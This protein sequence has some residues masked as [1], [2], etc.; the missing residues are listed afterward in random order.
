MIALDRLP[1]KNDP[2]LPVL[3]LQCT[4]VFC[5]ITFWGFNRSPAQVGLI[6]AVCV[7]L[8]CTLH[9][10]LRK[11]TLLVPISGLITGLGLSVLTN[12][13]HGLWLALV[14]PFFATASK[15]VFTVN[16]RHIYNPGLFGVIAALVLSDGMITPSPA[17]QWGGAGITAFFIAT[18]ALML[19]A[20][21]IR[22]SVLIASFLVFYA[23]Q[24]GLRAWL[25]RHHIPPQTLFM[26]AFSSPAFYLFTFFMITDP[27]TSAQTPK[28][29]VFMA[30]FIVFVDL[31]LHKF[32]SFSTL[33]Y[34]AFA[35]MTLRGLWLLW[36]NRARYARPAAILRQEAKALLLT[37][38]IG[39]G[40][41][42]AYRAT[43]AFAGGETHFRFVRIPAAQSGIGGTQGDIWERT[44]PRMHHIAKWLLSVGDAAAVADA[45]NDGLPDIFLTQ[46]L[47][48]EQDR[49]QLFLNKGNFRFERFDIPQLAPHRTHPEQHGLIAAATWFDM[50][51]DGDRDL[52]LGTGFGK[53]RL[54]RNELKETG[55]LNFTEIGRQSGLDNYQISV[56]TNVLDLDNDGKLD[57]FVGNVMQTTLGGYNRPVPYNIFK[58]PA[59]EYEGDRRMFNVMHQ[60]WHNAD[61]AD[62]NLL[63]RNLG[64]GRFARIPQEQT[65]FSG[66]RWTMAAATGDLNGDGYADLYI[67][68][69]FGPDELYLNR[70]GKGFLA[71]KGS[72]SGSVGRDT[73]KG[74]NATFGDLDD[75]GRPDIHVSNVHEKLQA[76]GSL[77]WMNYSQ[78]GQTDAAA[79]RDEAARRNALNERRFGWGAA[80]GDLDRDGRL[81]FVQANGMADDAYDKK[82]AVCPDYWYWNAQIALTNPDVHGYADRWADVRG[83]CVF[84]SEANRIYMNKGGYFTDAAEQAGWTEKGTSRGMILAD[85]DNDGDLDSLVTHMT[86]APSLYR[87]DSAPAGWIGLQLAGNGTSCNRDAQGTRA[88][89]S[90]EDSPTASAQH[91]EV[92]ANNGLAAQNDPRILFGLGSRRAGS[93]RIGIQWCGRGPVQS[94]TLQTGRYHRI[95]QQ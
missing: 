51:N 67:A 29:Q 9:Y 55:R 76:E 81:D 95:T 10:L 85:F 23:M 84:G 59:P 2:R 6:L 15:Y 41:W 50:D 57:I 77:L 83:R 1:A 66:K 4:F 48:S 64:G 74:M 79:F 91:R 47:K 56:A 89:L 11:K 43:H 35:Y 13:S 46:P 14:P 32:Q 90:A 75:N 33:F 87:N 73:Y 18:A 39:L 21:N 58:L 26:G 65:G 19:F 78:P 44:D 92:Y 16:G 42:G 22:R 31:L 61:N 88:V 37:G 86:A 5:G 63:F 70:Q 60:S 40:G 20:L 62:E 28:G 52:L 7:V 24:L 38:L 3:L 34:A 54:L 30:F 94:Y 12:F 71:V 36:Q 27:P 80:F 72:F 8:D 45:D 49:A 25:L 69:D 93:V 82:E 53:G 17:Y 68:N